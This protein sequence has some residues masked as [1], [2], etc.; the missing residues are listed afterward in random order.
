MAEAGRKGDNSHVGAD[1]H[2]CKSCP[3][4]ADGPATSGSGDVFINGLP[5]LRVGDTGSHSSCC[6][7]NTWAAR[8]GAPAVFFNGK[9]VHRKGDAVRHCGG[10]GVLSEGS[11][12]VFIGDAVVAPGGGPSKATIAALLAMGATFAMGAP[13]SV[14]AL[15]TEAL[16]WV[17][18]KWLPTG[19]MKLIGR[20]F[21][22]LGN[23]ITTGLAVA[24]W[25]ALH[26]VKIKG[27]TLAGY[28]TW[29]FN[30]VIDNLLDGGH[31]S[32]RYDCPIENEPFP[33][34][35]SLILSGNP[36]D[37]SRVS[38]TVPTDQEVD[39][40]EHFKDVLRYFQPVEYQYADDYHPI[41]LAELLRHGTLVF[42]VLDKTMKFSG[43]DSEILATYTQAIAQMSE[44]GSQSG[45]KASD[46]AAYIDV[47]DDYARTPDLGAT[48][49]VYGRVIRKGTA[50]APPEHP[51]PHA[52]PTW[53]LRLE[54]VHVRAGDFM[55]TKE[56]D[57][58]NYQHEGDGESVAL[59]IN[60]VN[61][62]CVLTGT[63]TG[64][65][66]GD[67]NNCEAVLTEPA[68]AE[69]NIGQGGAPDDRGPQPR[70]VVFIGHGSHS[71]SPTP[72]R[73]GAGFGSTD[74]FPPRKQGDGVIA[75]LP[76][77]IY[78]SDS[79]VREAV[80]TQRVVWGK[81]EGSYGGHRW[82]LPP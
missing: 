29:Y 13:S 48:K 8:T 55:P 47:D 57:E 40:T 59:F 46:R 17:A 76:T 14:G 45:K 28:G 51:P 15:L 21:K 26:A 3:H 69:E 11:A 56:L 65:H 18:F 64:G 1:S 25:I 74:W 60:V 41:S 16:P 22:S 2:G 30:N 37:A 61:N 35:F 42:P 38:K 43:G 19:F 10:S 24:G 23:W 6:G 44:D 49:T 5:A 53:V 73:R 54:Y 81:D 58:E 62:E 50:T 66:G 63:R 9:A 71:T 4:A 36:P 80:F 72:G 77:L 32:G 34:P 75:F 20:P 7:S 68:P 27:R 79:S 33:P 12:D 31:R 67:P 70:P 52:E 82:I 78:S 39:V